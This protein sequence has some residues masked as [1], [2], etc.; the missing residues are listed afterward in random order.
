VAPWVDFQPDLSQNFDSIGSLDGRYFDQDRFTPI[1][2]RLPDPNRADEVA[3]NEESARLYG[4]RVGQQLDLA[5]VNSGRGDANQ[6]GEQAVQPRLLIHSTIVGVGAFV[7]EVAQDDTDR[8]PLVLFTPAYVK[9]AKGLELYAWQGLVLRNGDS[10][11]AA[12]KQI[13]TELSGGGPQIYRSRRPIRSMPAS[14]ASGQAARH[15]RDHRRARMPRSGRPG[16]CPPC[17]QRTS[18]RHRRRSAPDR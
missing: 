16:T 5:T 12:V 14:D 1:R 7:E 6:D 11:V 8:S 18:T 15:V 10:D 9:E 13:I 3:V 4:Y 2:G 17:Q